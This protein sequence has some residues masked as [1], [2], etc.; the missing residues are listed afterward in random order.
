MLPFPQMQDN[1]MI[2]MIELQQPLLLSSQPH[3]LLEPNPPKPPFPPHPPQKNKRMMI[4]HMLFPPPNPEP[5]PLLH[6]LLHPHPLL[7]LALQSL[8]PQFDKSPIKS[9]HDFEYSISYGQ[10]MAMFP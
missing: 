5:H 6:P 1:K 10:G 8:H 9:L 7:D 4:H 2:Q 3:P